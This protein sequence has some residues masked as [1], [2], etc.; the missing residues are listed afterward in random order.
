MRRMKMA[1]RRVF[2]LNIIIG[3]VAT[4]DT[5]VK[6][7]AECRC[8]TVSQLA[9]EGPGRETDRSKTKRFSIDLTTRATGNSRSG[10][11]RGARH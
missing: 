4:I 7:R 5:R 9:P 2:H 11:P 6:R 10:I 3:P 8:N 1:R